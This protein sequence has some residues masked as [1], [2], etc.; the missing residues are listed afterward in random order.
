MS[1]RL[2]LDKLQFL[3]PVSDI[4]IA[5]EFPAVVENP[6]SASTGKPLDERTLYRAGGRAINGRKAHF[7]TDDYQVTIR[8]DRAGGLSLCSLQ[9]SAGAFAKSNLEPLGLDA[10]MD[11]TDAVQRD[12]AEKG[13]QADLRAARLV[14]VDISQN[15][16]LSH[17]VPCYAPA[18]AATGARKRVRRM[19]FGGTGFIIGNKTWE[20]GFYDK[21]EQMK[22]LGYSADLRPKNTVRPELRLMRGRLIRQAFGA[23]TLPHFLGAWPELRKVY[24]AALE[25][26]VF[27]HKLEQRKHASIDW[28]ELAALVVAAGGKRKWNSFRREAL[29]LLLVADMGLDAAKHFVVSELDFDGDAEAPRRQ[30]DRIYA[31]LEQ[32]SFALKAQSKTPDGHKVLKL[33]DEL[34]TRC[35]AA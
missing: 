28:S 19:D 12:L 1:A 10:C 34:K 14:R 20:I 21:G 35:L 4:D 27:R 8:H 22:V 29:P 23:E 3:M 18:L 33:Y 6:V 11:V 7:N 24:N 5:P 15:V 32:A 13:L 9:F 16:K 26:D 2:G 31:E 25:R 30:R 17:P